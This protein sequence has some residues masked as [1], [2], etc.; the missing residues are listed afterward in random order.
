[1]VCSE[2]FPPEFK[3]NLSVEN[4][5]PFPCHSMGNHHLRGDKRKTETQNT[6]TP[7]IPSLWSDSS[8]SPSTD[9]TI[10]AKTIS[11]AK[12]STMSQPTI[13]LVDGDHH[14]ENLLFRLWLDEPSKD[15]TIV[16]SGKMIRAHRSVIACASNFIGTVLLSTGVN[17]LLMLLSFSI[18]YFAFRLEVQGSLRFSFF[19]LLSYT[20]TCIFRDSTW[21][22]HGTI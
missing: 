7:I 20:T 4:K 15:L 11:A 16:A 8:A 14:V 22:I 10:S 5:E 6:P 2:H 21:K 18:Q 19:C 9:N 13:R 3:D 1:M 17:M 12:R